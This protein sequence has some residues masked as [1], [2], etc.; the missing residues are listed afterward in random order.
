MSGRGGLRRRQ[1][2]LALPI[3]D[4]LSRGV[5]GWGDHRSATF[6]IGVKN[7]DGMMLSEPFTS[8][9][10][11]SL[12]RKNPATRLAGLAG[13]AGGDDTDLRTVITRHQSTMPFR[14]RI[15]SRRKRGGQIGSPGQSTPHLIQDG[16]RVQDGASGDHQ[17]DHF[18]DSC[19]RLIQ[20]VL[21]HG[22]SSER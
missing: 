5:F 19:L 6:R 18:S 17:R 12:P 7:D 1:R 9:A 2:H 8:H 13:L 14:P 4:L 21:V 15:P 3:R 20:T 10:A 16:V 11:V 22:Q